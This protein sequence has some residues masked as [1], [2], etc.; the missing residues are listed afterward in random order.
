MKSSI[1]RLFLAGA[2]ALLSCA[3]GAQT[4]YF[5]NYDIT[6]GLPSNTIM[7]SMQD[8]RGFVWFGTKDGISRFDGHDFMLFGDEESQYPMSGLTQ[9]LCED[10]SGKIWFSTANGMGFYDPVTGETTALGGQELATRHLICDSEGSIWAFSGNKFVKFLKNGEK[11]TVNADF[12]GQAACLDSKGG[13]WFTTGDGKLK[14]ALDGQTFETVS[15]PDCSVVNIADAGNMKFILSTSDNRIIRYDTVTRQAETIV[16]GVLA[17]TTVNVLL[18]RSDTEYWIACMHGLYIYREGEGISDYITNDSQHSI[19]DTNVISMSTDSDGNIWLGTFHSGISLWHNETNSVSQFIEEKGD[20]EIRGRLVHAIGEDSYGRIWVG[21]EEGGLTVL[22]ADGRKPHFPGIREGFPEG[23]NYHSMITRGNELWIST[24]NDGIYVADTRAEKV[25][26]HYDVG[27]NSC[28]YIYESP[29]GLIYA[30]TRNGLFTYEPASDSFREIPGLSGCW[31]HSVYQDS[32]GKLWIGT[33]G[34]GLYTIGNNLMQHYTTET[35]NCGL[36][37]NYVTSFLE[38]KDSSIWLTT[39]GGGL[40][41]V[42]MDGDMRFS[43]FARKEGLPSNVACAVTQDERGILW[44]ST[45]KGLV[46]LDPSSMTILNVYLDNNGTVGDNFTYASCYVTK[47]GRIH[48]GTTKGLLV[49]APAILTG[50]ISDSPLYIVD[51]H[52]GESDSIKRLHTPGKSTI[53]SDR[54]TVRSKDA[55]YLSISFAAPNFLDI[56]RQSYEYSFRSKNGLITN[57]TSDNTAVFSN[58]RPG[59]YKFNVK[60]AGST[61]PESGK[62]LSIRIK[63][64][65]FLSIFAKIFYWLIAAGLVTSTGV[66]LRRKRESEERHQREILETAKQKELAEAKVNFFTNITHEIRTPLTLIKLPV[67]KII[68]SKGYTEESKEDI[69]TIQSNT[70]RLL[71]L[72]N[73]LLDIRNMEQKNFTLNLTKFDICAATRKI[74]GYFSPGIRERHMECSLDIPSKE[75]LIE[76]DLDFIEKI[77]CNLMSNAVKYGESKVSLKL[78]EDPPQSLLRIMVDSDGEHISGS[79]AEKIF[80][81]FY[82]IRMVN[83]QLVGSNGTGLG[84]PYAR[85]LAQALNGKL[86]LDTYRKDCNSFIF[87]FPAVAEKPAEDAD[88]GLAG[89]GM[90]D[91]KFNASDNSRHWLLVVEDSEEMNKYL[92]KELEKNYNI[93]N[94]TNGEEALDVIHN[95]RVDIVVSDIMMPVMDGCELCNNIKKDVEL[96][97]I[98]VI[99]LTAA[100]GVETRI[101]TLEVGA[102]GYIEKPFSIELLKANIDNLFKNREISYNQFANSPLSHFKSL[103]VNNIDQDFMD[104]LHSVVMDNIADQDLSIDT[105]TQLMCTSKSTLYRK[106]KANTGA[107]INEYIRI[108]KLKKAAEMLTSQKYRIN[109]VAYLTGFSS[110]SYFTTCFQK[111]FKISPSNFVKNLTK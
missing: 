22:F 106:V 85:Q 2:M 17:S 67:E 37:S 87:E 41:R 46:E 34:Q 27:A 55:P 92:C 26:R 18:A 53:M 57:T 42:S 1:Y 64:P 91:D 28:G 111:Q 19:Q 74:F 58:L 33:Y 13:L 9:S 96:S 105:L 98:P 70:T 77:I 63:P 12:S 31:I 100:V 104:K 73:Q 40:C 109:E 72:T 4:R 8:S 95:N 75:I 90:E 54:I 10:K 69:M 52:A 49:F 15:V 29:D 65:F 51:I 93:L 66:M 38:D 32:A 108:C 5:K 47:D 99:L 97:H 50:T 16:S 20:N 21:T 39:E 102:D 107:N 71:N 110:P 101:Q 86:Y 7:C 36:P 68:A 23:L 79:D 80:E 82:Q 24:F 76:S 43:S 94:A 14:H 60:I 30:G 61:R 62:E 83:S 48:M 44:V 56:N 103:V 45:T 59:R 89:D 3:A 78:E 6:D 35:P 11:V 84:L 88:T 81:Q 25:V